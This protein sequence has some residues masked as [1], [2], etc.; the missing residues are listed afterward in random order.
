MAQ[1]LASVDIGT[2]TVLMLCARRAEG[3][4]VQVL[5]QRGAVTRLGQGVE[6]LLDGL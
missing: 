6:A 1:A 5:A 4:A 3:G 2:N